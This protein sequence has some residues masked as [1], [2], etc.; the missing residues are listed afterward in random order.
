MCVLLSYQ[1]LDSAIAM[2]VAARVDKRKYSVATPPRLSKADA[3]AP[4]C[5]PL[6]VFSSSGTVS[7]FSMFTALSKRSDYL[8]LSG[9][10]G[11]M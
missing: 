2:L 11:L 3:M 9:A 1:T 5:G 10:V 4:L 7:V 6:S 8:T